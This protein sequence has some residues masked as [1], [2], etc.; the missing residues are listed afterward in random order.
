[1]PS[2]DEISRQL[3]GMVF[4]DESASKTPDR[5]ESTKKDRKKE[6]KKRK[7]E[8]KRKSKRNNKKKELAAAE[9]LWK[10]KNIFF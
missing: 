1:V 6:K 7:K 3:E 10:K 9:I 4:G 5:T 2:G 8:K